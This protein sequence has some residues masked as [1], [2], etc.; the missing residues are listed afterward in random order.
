MDQ[1]GQTRR[2][3]LKG[4]FGGAAGIVLGARVQFLAAAQAVSGDAAVLRLADDLFVIT[5]PGEANVVA[6]TG[7]AAYCLST[8]DRPRRRMQLMK[9][10]AAL[11]GGGRGAHA[12]QHALASRADRLERAARQGGQDDHRAREHAAVAGDGRHVVVE[13]AALQAAAEDRAAE[14]DVLHDGQAGFGRS[15]TATS[16]TPRTPTAI[17]TCTSRSRTCSPSATWCRARAGRSWT[18]RPAAG[19]AASSAACSGCRRSP[20]QETRIVPGRGPVL[21]LA[22]LKARPTCTR[23]STIV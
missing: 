1:R 3:I 12:V 9:A 2:Q 5:I 13:R 22:E 18:G 17:C 8:A 7:A 6:Q 4:A 21:G 23:R 19:L 20:T 15:S 10:V 11:P 14:Q 16:P